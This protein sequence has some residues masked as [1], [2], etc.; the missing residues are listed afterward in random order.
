MPFNI[1]QTQYIRRIDVLTRYNL[2]NTTL[3]RL[4]NA[5]KFPR[6]IA[7]GPRFVRWDV[8][9]LEIW[10]QAQKEVLAK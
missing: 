5:G 10:E 6:G 2:S 3:Y 1:A 8:D 9:E 4:I 7:F